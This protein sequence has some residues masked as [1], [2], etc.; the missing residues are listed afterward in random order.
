MISKTGKGD[1]GIDNIKI[2]SRIEEL[3]IKKYRTQGT[4][5]CIELAFQF[6]G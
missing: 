1:E 3:I 6:S 5:Q 2:Q 4:S